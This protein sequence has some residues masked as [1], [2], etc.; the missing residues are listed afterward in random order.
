MVKAI[1]DIHFMGYIHRD[2]KPKNMC[3]MYDQDDEA[4]PRLKL[5]DFG[6]SKNFVDL[7]KTHI[8]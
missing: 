2:I 6:I 1:R 8:K 7:N 4:V 3:V 5:I